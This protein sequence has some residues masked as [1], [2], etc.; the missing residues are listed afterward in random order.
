MTINDEERRKLQAPVCSIYIEDA[1]VAMMGWQKAVEE[2][3]IYE[4]LCGVRTL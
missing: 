3:E 1:K 4:C 2:E